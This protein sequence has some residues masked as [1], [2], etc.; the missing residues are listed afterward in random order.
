MVS[1]YFPQSPGLIAFGDILQTVLLAIATGVMFWNA[2]RSH[3]NGRYFWGLN[4][5]GCAMWTVATGFWVY[6]EVYRGEPSLPFPSLVDSVFFL[7]MVPMIGAVALKP[8]VYRKREEFQVGAID[9]A[10]LL[11]WWIYLYLLVVIPWQYVQQNPELYGK[12]FNVLYAFEKWTLLAAIAYVWLRAGQ[13]WR[14]I[15]TQLFIAAL[16]YAIASAVVNMGIIARKYYTGSL[17]DVPLVT[18]MLW[19]IGA[20]LTASRLGAE[21]SVDAADARGRN[22]WTARLA[23]A[24]ILSMPL[25]A[26]WVSLDREVPESVRNFRLM[27]TLGAVFVLTFLV[28]LKEHLIDKEL[29]RLLR[30][31]TDALEDLKR[32]QHQLV[33]VEKMASLGQL[34]AGAAH[35]IN[36]PLTAILGYSEIIADDA[37]LPPEKRTLADKIGQQA[38]RVKSLVADLLQFA[39]QTPAEKMLVNI[40]ILIDN[41]L[42][43]REAELEARGMRFSTDLA[44]TLPYV[45][46]DATQLLQV[47][48]HLVNNAADAMSDGSGVL[49]V[50]AR[51]QNGFL[52]IEFADSGTGVADPKKVFDPFFTT[53]AVGK[54]AGLGL[55][56]CYGI[57]QQHGGTISCANRP[58]GGATFTVRLPLMNAQRSVASTLS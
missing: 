1:A 8:H 39:R 55:S 42:R 13:K 47:F 35:E 14:A 2:R 3:A 43:S 26:F 52:Q 5:L 4:A 40:N 49:H 16:I 50:S 18:S 56:A 21:P 27:V 46:G 33:Q 53:K 31:S 34:V 20:G 6:Y 28:F 32:V 58:E 44:S 41:A 22:M 25:L 54:G 15:Y 57:V 11:L 23:M 24:A 48:N 17:Y 51:E 36:N 29:L 9:F 30:S 10:L 38:R 45:Q 37:S 12:S 7:H 19:Y